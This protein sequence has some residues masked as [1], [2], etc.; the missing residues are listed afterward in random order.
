MRDFKPGTDPFPLKTKAEGVR[1]R[2]EEGKKC[3]PKCLFNSIT[4]ILTGCLRDQLQHTP[5]SSFLQVMWETEAFKGQI[6][7]LLVRVCSQIPGLFQTWSTERALH[8]ELGVRGMQL[9]QELM[10]R[11]AADRSSGILLKHSSSATD[12][13]LQLRI[14]FWLRSRS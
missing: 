10:R 2:K 4:K 13:N 14:Q 9:M 7:G 8:F 1:R 11:R 3:F 5:L 12:A 6:W